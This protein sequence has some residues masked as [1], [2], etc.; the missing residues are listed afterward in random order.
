MKKAVICIKV[1]NIIPNFRNITLSFKT[2]QKI[3][4]IAMKIA[5]G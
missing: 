5:K 3:I 1:K 4:E 2:P